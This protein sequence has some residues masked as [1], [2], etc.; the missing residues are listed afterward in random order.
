MSYVGCLDCYFFHSFLGFRSPKLD[1][2]H[3]FYSM[4]YCESKYDQVEILC[5]FCRCLLSDRSL[6]VSAEKAHKF[7]FHSC[8][9][10]KPITAGHICFG[11][12]REPPGPEDTAPQ[13][14]HHDTV[15]PSMAVCPYRGRRGRRESS[16]LYIFI[17]TT[18]ERRREW[19]LVG[20]VYPLLL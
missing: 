12:V 13:L 8:D 19:A 11:A 1:L 9:L 15:P 7:H 4:A 14:S 3:N 16:G 6:L 5:L 17:L 20:S 2:N 18:P 10:N